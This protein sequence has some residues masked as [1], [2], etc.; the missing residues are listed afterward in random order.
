MPANARPWTYPEVSE[1]RRLVAADRPDRVIAARLSRSRMA[2]ALKR[3]RLGLGRW[4]LFRHDATVRRL[5]ALGCHDREIAE[6]L[7]VERTAVYRVRRR[8]GLVAGRFAPPRG[9]DRVA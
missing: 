1:L 6:R 2:I 5:S 3:W 8:L 9:V 4:R 7:G